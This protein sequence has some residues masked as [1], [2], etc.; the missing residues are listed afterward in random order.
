LTDYFITEEYLS[1]IN[2]ENKLGTG[3]NLVRAYAHMMKAMWSGTYSTFNPYDF[4]KALC[5]FQRMFAGN[6][7][8]D[9]G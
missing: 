1:D 6:E 2:Q 3:G 8:H 9:S 4:K 5:R 7:Q